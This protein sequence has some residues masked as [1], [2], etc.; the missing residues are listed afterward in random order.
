MVHRFCARPPLSNGNSLWCKPK[1]ANWAFRWSDFVKAK[2]CARQNAPRPK[3]SCDSKGR[4][5]KADPGA[6]AF[7]LERV[8]QLDFRFQRFDPPVGLNE[9]QVLLEKGWLVGLFA[10][11]P[12]SHGL[13]AGH[14]GGKVLLDTTVTGCC[15]SHEILT[16]Q[17]LRT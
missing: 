5:S 11:S 6:V 2:G 14:L 7:F 1:R 12:Q 4:A 16:I 13:S 15:I 10:K 9:G 17:Q 3:R 8:G